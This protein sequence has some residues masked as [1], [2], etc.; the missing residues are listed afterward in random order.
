MTQYQESMIQK[1][2]ELETEARTLTEKL[3]ALYHNNGSIQAQD[4]ARVTELHNKALM[5]SEAAGRAEG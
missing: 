3:S 1:S 5:R 4:V 2:K